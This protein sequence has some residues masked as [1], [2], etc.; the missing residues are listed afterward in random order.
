MN[1]T[2][3]LDLYPT[4]WRR[5]HEAAVHPALEAADVDVAGAIDLVVGA[6]NAHLRPDPSWPREDTGPA[7][8][9]PAPGARDPRRTTLWTI[10]LMGH[11]S[12]YIVVNAILAVINLLVEPGNPWFLYPLWGWGIALAAH[13]GITYSGKSWLLAH[14]LVSI[15]VSLGLAGIDLTQGASGWSIWV[16]WALMSL[17]AVHALHARGRIGD[18]GAH[19]LATILGGLELLAVAVIEPSVL[20]DLTISMGYWLVGLLV[21]AL[22]RFGQPTLLQAHLA[23]FAAMN[24]LFA[25]SSSWEDDALWFIYPLV[26][27]SVLLAAHAIL[28]FQARQGRSEAWED[29]MLVAIEAGDPPSPEGRQ[30]WKRLHRWSVAAH[31]G[32]FG[33]GIAIF[34]LLNLLS[35]DGGPWL[36]WPISVWLVL[37]CAHLGVIAVADAPGLGA[38]LLGGGAAAIWIFVLD[39]QTG[40][41]T[42]WFWPVGVWALGTLIVVPLTV[43]LLQAVNNQQHRAR[44]EG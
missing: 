3:M 18:F 28:A 2:W 42:W 7:V 34:G 39:M 6:A 40:G 43:D 13:V 8:E 20:P 25:L 22:Y 27:W 36:V 41:N 30:A 21:H 9:E 14:A 37:F 38:H 32:L 26:A 24:A 17:L 35:T 5:R 1:A 12:L 16:T 11:V 19:V 33:A 29:T 23:S 15:T 44:P 31:A 10:F 4:A